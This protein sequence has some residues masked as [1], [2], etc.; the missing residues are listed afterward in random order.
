[1]AT[2]LKKNPFVKLPWWFAIEA[3]KATKST[4]AL[5]WVELVYRA[6]KAKSLTFPLPNMR[7]KKMGVGREAKRR[8]LRDLEAAKLIMIKR[9]HKKAPLVTLIAL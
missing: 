1:M 4:K 6:W 3:A 7:L 9:R 5:V 2:K 8:V